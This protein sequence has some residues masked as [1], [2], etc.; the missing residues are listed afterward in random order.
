LNDD[1]HKQEQKSSRE[2]LELAFEIAERDFGVVRVLD[3]ED[4]VD[5]EYPDEK[6]IITYVS[7]LHDALMNH[8]QKMLNSY[9]ELHRNLKEWLNEALNRLEI[10]DFTLEDLHT[11]QLKEYIDYLKLKKRLVQLKIDLDRLYDGQIPLRKDYE[12]KIIDVLWNRFEFNLKLRLNKVEEQFKTQEQAKILIL[13]LNKF[14]E[15]CL[16]KCNDIEKE[17]REVIKFNLRFIFV[18]LNFCPLLDYPKT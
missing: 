16:R 11:F 5:Q 15:N 6:S 13:K 2:K 12:Y 4:L 14:C 3:V 7:M 18:G 9:Q 8:Q 17:F 10:D 1:E